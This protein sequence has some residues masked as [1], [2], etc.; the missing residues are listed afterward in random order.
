M[1]VVAGAGR[2]A[3]GADAEPFTQSVPGTTATLEMAP[4]P[5]LPGGT[6]LHISTTEIT[7]DLYDVFVYRLDEEDG[8]SPSGADAVSRPSRRM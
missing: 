6:P 4:I 8:A 3:T 2:A 5:A 1:V 7:W